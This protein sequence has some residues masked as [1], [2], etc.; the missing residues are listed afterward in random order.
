MRD[1]DDITT[2]LSKVRKGRDTFFLSSFAAPRA[3]TA[4]A[5]AG[6]V[7]RR[8]KSST[9]FRN[10]LLFLVSRV[11][12]QRATHTRQRLSPFS[13]FYHHPNPKQHDTF[14]FA[15]F[16]APRAATAGA[17]PVRRRLCRLKS[18]TLFHALLVFLVSLLRRVRLSVMM[19]WTFGSALKCIALR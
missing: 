16:A 9:L 5:G 1:K 6:A 18:S 4:T 14:F 11:F 7:R 12:S 8:L 2:L 13:S 17:G 10:L 19:Y 3:A 15:S